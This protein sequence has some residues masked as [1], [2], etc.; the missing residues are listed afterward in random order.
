MNLKVLLS[1]DHKIV[2]EGL[3]NLLYK[4]PAIEIVA[5]SENGRETVELALKLH[6]DIV[7]MDITM[8]ELNGIEAARQIVKNLPD[9]KVIALTMHSERQFVLEMLK[10][11]A[12]AYLLKDCAFDELLNAIAAVTTGKVYISPSIAHIVV[13]SISSAEDSTAN[14]FK[15]LTDRER[16]ILQL[17]SEGKSTK[18]IAYLLSISVKT[19]ETYRQQVMNK[20]KIFNIAEL[21]KYAIREGI[22]SVE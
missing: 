3:K 2:R 1:D 19:V 11:G 21:T 14:S 15:L 13:G 20:L 5:E 6:P 22:T 9:T 4:N 16:E 17:L 7:I 18:E 8:P 12:S 10:A